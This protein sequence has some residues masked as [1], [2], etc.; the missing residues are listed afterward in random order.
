MGTQCVNHALDTF[1]FKT[2]PSNYPIGIYKLQSHMQI[3]ESHWGN[4]LCMND[5]TF[6]DTSKSKTSNKTSLSFSVA[7]RL[8]AICA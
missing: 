4:Y 6:Q 7:W 2:S 3:K 1:A 5:F 8:K